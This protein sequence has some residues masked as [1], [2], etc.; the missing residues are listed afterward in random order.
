MSGFTLIEVLVV[1]A[2][3][4]ILGGIFGSSLIRS[5]RTAELREAANQVAS[6][7]QRARSLAQRGST[8]VTITTSKGTASGSYSV[9]GQARTLPNNIKLV[10]KTNCGAGTAAAT[11]YQAPYGELTNLGSVFTVQSPAGG[12]AALE[13]RIVGVT[14][15]VILTGAS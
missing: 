13:I 3:I 15:K 4:G 1:I 9:D 2:I 7:F 14:G 8:N 11:T 12:V 5:I 6:D 10:C